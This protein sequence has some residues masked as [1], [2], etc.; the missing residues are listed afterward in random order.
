[1]RRWSLSPLDPLDLDSDPLLSLVHLVCSHRSIYYKGTGL[2]VTSDRV[3][4]TLE[5]I[6]AFTRRT[7]TRWWA[8]W[9][10]SISLVSVT[11][12]R[13]IY[14]DRLQSSSVTIKYLHVCFEWSTFPPDQ[15]SWARIDATLSRHKYVKGV[16][17]DLIRAWYYGRSTDMTFPPY[18]YN[19]SF[20]QRVTHATSGLD[21]LT[22]PVPRQFCQQV[23]E[24]KILLCPALDLVRKG[25]WPRQIS[26]WPD[27]Y[28][29]LHWTFSFLRSPRH[30]YAG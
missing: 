17:S 2:V 20:K 8:R 30:E 27:L 24:P 13:E 3:S 15:Q 26:F 14:L 25:T 5:S 11:R 6:D 29:C 7:Y 22:V 9:A 21:L 16:W 4:N 18:F 12:C 23:A 28:L 1:M 10:S 19:R